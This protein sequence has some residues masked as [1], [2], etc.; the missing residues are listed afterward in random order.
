M[1]I[2]LLSLFC[3]ACPAI[4]LADPWADFEAALPHSAGDLSEDQ[5]DQLIQAA[6]AVEAWASDLEWATPTAADGAPLPADPDEVLRVVRTLVDAKQRADAALANNWPLR[7]EFVQLT[8]GAENRQRLGHYLRT[9]STL[10]DLSGRI[11]YRMRDVLDSA[12]YELDPH[13]PQ[14]EAMIE[15]LTK[16]RVEIGGTALS[17]V[18]LDPAPETGAVPYSPAVKAKVLRLLATV[19]DMEMVPDVVTLLEQPTTTPELAI[20]AAETIRQI[21]LPQDARPGTPTPLAPSITAAQLRDHLTALNDRTLRPQLKAAR[22]SL[23]AWA[24][25]RAEHGVTGDSYRVGDF[26]VKSGD[27]LLMRNPSPY[28]MFTDISPGLFTHVGVVATEVGEDGKRRFVIV[29]LPERGAKIPATNVDDYL[30]RTLHYMFLRHNDPAVQQQLG[31]AAAEMIGNRSNFDLTFRTSRVLDLKG[32]PLKGQTIN[33]YCAGFLL[34]CAQT[35]SRPRT[36]FFPIPE[37]AAG[38]N[39]L[40][41]LKKLGLAIGDDFVSPSGAIFSPAL[42]IAGRREPMYSPDRQLKE[43][44]YDHFAVSMVE[45]T[46]HPAPDL[47]QAMLESAAR[48]A[49]QNA[50]LR[51]FLARANN[52]SPEMDL[53]SA[54]KAAAV[55]ETLD[56][57]ADANMSGFLKAREAFVAGPL[58]ALRQS[59]ASEQRVAE[60][61]QYRQRHADLWNRWIAGQ[62][63]PRDMRIA[64]VDF[65]SQQ[66]RDQ[67]DEKF[68]GP[69]AP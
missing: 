43:A 57:I 65:Y 8:D 23:L 51:Q 33:T 11:R 67:L 6:D 66:G 59:G 30:L 63:S 10:I 3:L 28:N 47:S 58:E 56:A 44:V 9:T 61:T 13:P 60:I 69:A 37:Y 48:I 20:L 55:I 2:L 29:D 64:L 35:T 17:Y 38:G 25:E 16:H 39:C 53:E 40:S 24:S 5:V 19:R 62:L 50:W 49:K 15:M 7:K 68:F 36:E 1:R 4:V 34:L 27:W 42:E 12:T 45:E 14:F 21:G 22:Q 31:A 41:N 52:V 18:L 46:L 26:E 54:A 32:K